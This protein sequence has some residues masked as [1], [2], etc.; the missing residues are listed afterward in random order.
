MTIK[1]FGHC[2]LLIEERSVRILTDPGIYTVEK[3]RELKNIDIVLYT[4][5]HPDHYHLESLKH[6]VANNPRVK[7]LCNPGVG[8]QL[9]KRGV[10][11]L[12][13]G[14]GQATEERGV[15]IEGHGNVHATLHPALPTVQNTG[16]F[17]AGRFWYSGDAFTDPGRH[18]E[19]LA[20]PIIGPWMKLSEAIDYAL[21]Q[22]PKL[23]FP[24]HDGIL[25]EMFLSY[26]SIH[27][28]PAA[29]LEPHGIQFLS[30]ELDKEYV[31]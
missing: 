26:G 19:I 2:C 10:A 20:L 11:H 14:D 12:V 16:Y 25:N 13:I 28:A 27:K 23:C 29:V 4:H 1:K 3:Q 22:K 7:V 15:V 6:I 9:S 24:V 31:V 17:I 8:A 5:E 30:V 21:A 18:A